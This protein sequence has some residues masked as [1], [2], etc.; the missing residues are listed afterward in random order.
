MCGYFISHFLKYL[1]GIRDSM[2]AIKKEKTTATTRGAG[3]RKGTRN[4]TGEP[5]TFSCRHFVE[6][7]LSILLRRFEKRS[8]PPGT[9][10]NS[11]C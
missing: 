7:F 11:Y 2:E 4:N 10:T 6:P 1:C 8:S 9:G 3:K 5:A